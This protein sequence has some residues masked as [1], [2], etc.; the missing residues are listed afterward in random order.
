MTDAEI[1]I[2]I[3]EKCGW[4]GPF[5]LY[6]RIAS[7]KQL[8]GG[9]ETLH[10]TPPR[11]REKPKDDQAY[12]PVPDFPNDLNACH[13]FEKTLDVNGLGRYADELDEVCVPTHIC[14]LTHWKAVVMATAR[15]RCEAF[16]RVHGLWGKV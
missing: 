2:A 14:P 9:G 8:L 13:E 3:A 12:E 10:G 6:R 4:L 1:R 5:G 7:G 16:L 15:Q 11:D